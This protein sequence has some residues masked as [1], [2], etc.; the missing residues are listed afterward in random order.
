LAQYPDLE[1]AFDI[2]TRT[3]PTAQAG[4]EPGAI[5]PFLIQPIL[6][7]SEEGTDVVRLFDLYLSLKSGGW[8]TITTCADGWQRRSC[9]Q[10]PAK[11]FLINP[12]ARLHTGAADHGCQGKSTYQR[13][14]V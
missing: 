3:P 6:A 14:R 11:N 12:V 9:R 4:L 8:A 7:L 13:C 2:P 5:S 1:G 10:K